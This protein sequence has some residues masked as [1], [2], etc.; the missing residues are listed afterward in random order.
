MSTTT[1][2]DTTTHTEPSAIRP[3]SYAYSKSTRCS[4]KTQPAPPS[5]PPCSS[6]SS[7]TPNPANAAASAASN[8]TPAPCPPTLLRRIHR[9]PARGV[10]RQSRPRPLRRPKRS[11]R[12][13]RPTRPCPPQPAPR[14]L[15]LCPHR[16][17]RIPPR[18][19]PRRRRLQAPP[20]RHRA[21]PQ[22]RQP[23]TRARRHIRPPPE[24]PLRRISRN[25]P[26]H[27][28]NRLRRRLRHP[29]RHRPRS[30][31][32]PRQRI[33]HPHR[34]PHRPQSRRIHRPHPLPRQSPV[35]PRRNRPP[36]RH[37]PTLPRR[38]RP[39]TRC[40]PTSSPP[41]LPSAPPKSPSPPTPP[42]IPGPT[43]SPGT[44]TT[45]PSTPT[46]KNPASR[47]KPSPP[48][49]LSPKLSPADLSK[50][51]T[52]SL[53]WFDAP[54]SREATA[55]LLNS[56]TSA[57]L[58][59][60]HS[61]A[62]Y[63]LAGTPTP[64]TIQYA[65]FHRG[66]LDTEAKTSKESP[67]CSPTSTYPLRTNWAPDPASLNDSAR[68]LARLNGWLQLESSHPQQ[69]FRLPRQARPPRQR[70]QPR[71][72]RRRKS[73]PD[74]YDLV[75]TGSPDAD[76]TTRWVYVLGI[77]CQGEGTLVWPY[78]AVRLTSIPTEKGRLERIKLAGDPFPVCPPS[79]PTPT[80]SSPPPPAS[81]TPPPS[82]SRA[83]S[84]EESTSN[85]QN[86]PT[87]SKTSSTPPAPEPAAT[88]A[89]PHTLERPNPPHSKFPQRNAAP[90]R[91]PKE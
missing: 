87:L 62:T 70:R 9:H 59:P 78:D 35:S 31:H 52:T 86:P 85:P 40:K 68:Q 82:S 69:S 5:S 24:T 11:I 34:N 48:T 65:W 4:I 74:L 19:P 21:S 61:Q 39:T 22:L 53:I 44:P 47:P 71:H 27:R 3:G 77:N 80:S 84:P 66:D 50:L 88:P 12:H 33:H 43:T 63:V 23:A 18:Q 83:Y 17:P 38:P 13:R 57:R 42:S 46:P 73:F 75:F 1:I 6:A 28:R 90:R 16:D 7:P 72:R 15:H 51:P 79:A 30:R 91:L 54:L 41:S 67:G 37:R 81:K 76:P 64:N 32:R 56:D 58:T 2:V 26:S 25:R 20:G 45:G 29:P 49:P 14:P 10:P 8:S 55:S 60:N 36:A 89:P